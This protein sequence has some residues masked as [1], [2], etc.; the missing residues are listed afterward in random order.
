MAEFKYRPLKDRVLVE[1]HK[2][3]EKTASGIIIPDSAQEKPQK[4]TVIAVGNG[5]K[6][7]PMS[8]KKG[9][10]VMYGKYSGTEIKIDGKDYIIMKEDDILLVE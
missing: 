9:D 4:G 8:V 6:D 2:A 10:V 5:K 3:E 1:P 7:E